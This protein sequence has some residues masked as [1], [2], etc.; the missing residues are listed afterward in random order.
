[1]PTYKDFQ[2]EPGNY[3]K[4]AEYYDN[5]ALVLGIRNILL[6][7]PGNFPFNPLIGVDIEQYMFDLLDDNTIADIQA[8]INRQVA[9]YMPD[10]QN[11]QVN[12]EK[13]EI[14]NGTPYLAISVASNMNGKETTANFI[15]KQENS[16]VSIF[17][18][19][20]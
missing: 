4:A 19:I 2:F 8:E 16:I 15:L 3:N 18:E 9:L 1:M 14:S 10:L 11:I 7:R 17:N 5:N 6:S 12:V 20:N 13:I